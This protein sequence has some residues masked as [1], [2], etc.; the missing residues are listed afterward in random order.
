MLDPSPWISETPITVMVVREQWFA[1]VPMFAALRESAGV[2][3]GRRRGP[4]SGVD[5]P[6][7]RWP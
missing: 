6:P 4:L 1:L 2:V 7:E 3:F 5:L